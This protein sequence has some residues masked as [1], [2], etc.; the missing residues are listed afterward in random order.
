MFLSRLSENDKTGMSD[1]ISDCI[2]NGGRCSEDIAEYQYFKLSAGGSYVV[3]F[4]F[5]AGSELY[6]LPGGIFREKCDAGGN[7]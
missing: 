4:R 2:G 1:R 7:R 6:G 3:A 5:Y